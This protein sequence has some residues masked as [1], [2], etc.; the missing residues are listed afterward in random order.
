MMETIMTG[1]PY[2]QKMIR[3]YGL[4]VSGRTAVLPFLGSFFDEM[5]AFEVSGE[6][7]SPKNDSPDCI[8]PLNKKD[9]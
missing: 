5:E 6:V 7:N 8:K 2:H 4:T 3:I 9:Q 1:C